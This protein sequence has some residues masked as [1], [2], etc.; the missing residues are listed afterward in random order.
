MIQSFRIPGKLPGMN[1]YTKACR[2]SRFAGSRMK[3]EAQD[4]VLWSIKA[5]RLNPEPKMVE[6]CF[7]FNEPNRR[8]D[9]DN[10]SGFAHKVIQDALVESG[11][12]QG[13]GWKYIRGYRDTFVTTCA[14]E[15]PYIEVTIVS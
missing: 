10:I 14:G 13:D 7:F 12:I 15:E 1:E 11:V 6:L 4:R 5:A 3:R 2:T 9:M 8:R